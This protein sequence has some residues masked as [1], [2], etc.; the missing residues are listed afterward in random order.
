VLV[1]VFA[2][3][4]N[5]RRDAGANAQEFPTTLPSIR[6]SDR[7]QS[8]LL[9]NTAYLASDTVPTDWTGSLLTGDAGY[10]S[11][12][13]LGA[14][15]LR[16]N[17][18][19]A[20]A[21]V[22]ATIS[23]NDEWNR[24]DQQA[25]LM[26]SANQSLS[27]FP[28]PTWKFYTAEGAEGA[29]NSDLSIGLT[30]PAA[31]SGL[32]SDGGE[33]N[34]AAG[35]RRWILYQQT[36]TM[37]S[38][39]V[40]A[41]GDYPAAAA[42][43]VF[44]GNYGKA[45]PAT[46]EE[47][48]AWP[49]PGFVPYQVVF[50]RWSFSLSGADFSKATVAVRRGGTNVP[51]RLETV[52]TGVGENSIVWVPDNLDANAEFYATMDRPQQDTTMDVT[53]SS[54]L[55]AGALKTFQYSVT[56]FDPQTLASPEILPTVIGSN[57]A[58]IGQESSFG[59]S[60]VPYA[61]GYV[62]RIGTRQSLAFSDG[63]ENAPA[64]LDAKTSAGYSIIANDRKASGTASFHLIQT[65]FTSQSLTLKPLILAGSSTSLTFS[66]LLGWAIATQVAKV[67]VSTDDGVSWEDAFSEPGS[68]S[69]QSN[70]SRVTLD[71]SGYAQRTIR[72][73]FNF[74][75]L[76]GL[77]YTSGTPLGWYIDDI[78]L[79]GAETLTNMT[80]SALSGGGG[81]E[82]SPSS[83]GEYGIQA[84]AQF[85][86]GFYGVWGSVKALEVVPSGLWFTSLKRSADGSMQL[87]V[88]CDAGQ[89]FAIDR[90]TDLAKWVRKFVGQGT[91]G[92]VSF[93]DSEAGG[94]AKV[95]YRG[96]KP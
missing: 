17:Y 23:F 75:Y 32:I 43:W 52:G 16:V 84:R 21:G 34:S 80:S 59:V 81:I 67:Q 14:V 85:F 77:A 70:F 73:R 88:R 3:L 74:A 78:S 33:N 24:K 94:L 37:G 72:I 44:D 49:P 39:N 86:N 57:T 83:P 65:D 4:A 68:D 26:M 20:M 10:T 7:E 82:F 8:R 2:C 60:E 64:N 45:R 31:I 41:T 66:S 46:R 91:A 38:G 58:L 6:T 36:Q 28:P 62:W 92:E 87:S 50:P 56:A 71:L 53:V 76:G 89:T 35:H 5:N 48:V 9:F 63:A 40:P 90:S 47:F 25:A 1:L 12:D 27:H 13:F 42:L 61:T 69:P 22:P 54:V 29:Q 55:V 30:G 19:R 79:M 15:A 18:F 96:I 93:T 11:A 51:V 95:F